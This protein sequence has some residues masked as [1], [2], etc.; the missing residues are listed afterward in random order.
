MTLTL[1]ISDGTDRERRPPASAREPDRVAAETNDAA[2]P[3]PAA[4]AAAFLADE[5]SAARVLAEHLLPLVTRLVRRLAAWSGDCDDLVQDVLVTALTK[6]KTFAAHAKLETWITRI[7]INRC[8]THA[9][10]E[11]LRR[12]LLR[13]WVEQQ[14]SSLTASAMP[15]AAFESDE[16][17][18]AVR[19]AVAQLTQ[20]GREAIVLCYLEGLTVSEAAQALGVR[21]GTLEVRITRA[22]QQLRD[23][24]ANKLELSPAK[25]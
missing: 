9:R 4:L 23:A 16:R 18:N 3:D 15:E 13:T 20:Q 24:L 1:P 19:E 6:R 5:A 2:S 17:A 10:K 21:R 7:T 25:V 14:P 22:R 8:R 12:K 11:W